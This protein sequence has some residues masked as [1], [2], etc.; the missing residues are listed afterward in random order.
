MAPTVTARLMTILYLVYSL[1]CK[2]ESFVIQ[3]GCCGGVKRD[4]Q[5]T[6]RTVLRNSFPPGSRARGEGQY[7]PTASGRE[8]KGGGQGAA[9]QAPSRAAAVPVAVACRAFAVVSHRRAHAFLARRFAKRRRQTAPPA[10]R[11]P[12][13]VHFQRDHPR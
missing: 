9:R 10:G 3:V 7:G 8:R 11:P 1:L 2:I 13:R 6:G 12:G 4:G 5:Y